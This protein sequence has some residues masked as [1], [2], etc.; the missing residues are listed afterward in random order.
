MSAFFILK[1]TGIFILKPWYKQD[2]GSNSIRHPQP[3]PQQR[4][5]PMHAIAKLTRPNETG[6]MLYLLQFFY[7][8]NH[9]QCTAKS[10]LVMSTSLYGCPAGTDIEYL[11]C[12]EQSKHGHVDRTYITVNSKASCSWLRT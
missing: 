4:C 10:H 5:A 8:D 2:A 6:A 9:K 7:L 12:R 11:R 3:V 1:P